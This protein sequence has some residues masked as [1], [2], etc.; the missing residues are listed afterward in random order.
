MPQLG[1]Y[2]CLMIFSQQNLHVFLAVVGTIGFVPRTS[3]LCHCEGRSGGEALHCTAL[4]C[5]ALHCTALHCTAL[6]CFPCKPSW[7]LHLLKQNFAFVCC[8]LS[9]TCCGHNQSASARPIAELVKGSIKYPFILSAPSHPIPSHPIPSHPIPSRPCQLAFFAH[10][11]QRRKSG[12]PFI[13]HPVEVARIL[14]GMVSNAWEAVWPCG[15]VLD[16]SRWAA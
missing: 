12:E 5:T 3:R 9:L 7:H 4:H 16:S 10:D 1:S 6:H 2:R 11:G 13:T 14:A 15:W 8:D